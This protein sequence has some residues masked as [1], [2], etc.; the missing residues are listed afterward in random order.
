MGGKRISSLVVPGAFALFAVSMVFAIHSTIEAV[1]E[2]RAA[3]AAMELRMAATA[4]DHADEVHRLGGSYSND[5]LMMSVQMLG[6][7]RAEA[8]H[9]LEPA[10]LAEA[11]LLLD[12]IANHGTSLLGEGHVDET[13]HDH[14]RLQELLATATERSSDDA[15]AAE[16]GAAL[17]LGLTSLVM[18]LVVWVVTRSRSRAL[19]A[20]EVAIAQHRA[21]QRFEVLLND[22]P[23]ILVVIDSN[24]RVSYRSQSSAVLLG[25]TCEM[26]DDL[27]ELAPRRMQ[28]ALRDHLH[29]AEVDRASEVFQLRCGGSTEQADTGGWFDIRISDLA[30]DPL[31]AG[32]LVTIREV[33]SEVEL[34]AELEHQATTDLL[35]G[36]PN[37]RALAPELDKATAMV[38]QG[39]STMAVMNLDIDGFKMINDTLGHLAGDELLVQ[40]A[41]RLRN[42]TREGETILRLGGDEFILIVPSISGSAAAEVTATRLL[43]VLREPF[44]LGERVEHVRTSIG[45]AT[46]DDADQVTHLMSRAD[47]ALYEAK[48]QGGDQVIMF[49][50]GL[51]S[52]TMRRDQ[53]ARA[54]RDAVYDDEFRLVY[55]PI[56]STETGAIS[57]LEALLR[58]S[59]PP[60]GEVF[61]DEFIPIAEVTGEICALGMWVFDAVCAQLAE[62]VDAGMDP[63]IALSVNVSPRQ[64]VEEQVASNMLDIARHHHVDPTRIVIEITESAALDYSGN[65]QRRIEQLRAVGFRISIDD[66]GAG[67][68][69]LGRLLS[70]PFDIIKIDRSLLLM[71]SAMRAQAGGD[72]TGPCAILES[73]VTIA[74]ILGV[75]VVCEGVET[76]DQLTS[77]RA[78][79]ISHVQGY[80]TGRP[81]APAV[82]APMLQL[83]AD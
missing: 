79:G 19:H 25:P 6:H 2:D 75:P 16:R 82:V 13:D 54:L 38:D 83:Q 70:V 56:V 71:L 64:L 65:V 10:E 29:H 55:Q 49:E 52:T 17:A 67:Y 43:N 8:L 18:V 66:F 47:I 50:E 7:H 28:S 14:N 31:V 35:T 61:P 53:L 62:W 74:G 30:D 58:W 42:V 40:V 22:S 51:E 80:L 33:T 57:S 48:K 68:S 69:N 59:S 21:G 78:S 11:D 23:D 3:T 5:E 9:A 44:L 20:R 39:G 81:S 26:L 41:A 1:E 37:R 24:D 60:L 27:V 73:I 77:L 36:L 46:T 34:R 76:E 15:I 12:E 63:T 72:P 32:R 4:V 45:I